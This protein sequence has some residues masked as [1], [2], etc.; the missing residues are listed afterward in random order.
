MLSVFEPRLHFLAEWWKQLFGESEGKEL[1]GIFPTSAEFTTELHSLG[2]YIQQGKR[3]LMET[4]LIVDGGEV[5][6]KVP[7]WKINADGMNYL[8][9]KE[10]S[11]V[12]NIAYKATAKAH[13]EG[14]VP[15]CTIIIEKLDAMSLG[16]LIYFFEI[17][18]AITCSLAGVNPFNQP[19]VE[20]YK[21]YM[22]EMLGKPGYT[23][24]VADKYE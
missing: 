5:S 17:A 11:Y 4:F 16:A 21:G 19:G 3:I 20:A 18:C 2:Q 8:A 15:N 6:L 10:V 13:R 9:G 24:A 1:T 14:G 12:N 7:E 23:K 22:F